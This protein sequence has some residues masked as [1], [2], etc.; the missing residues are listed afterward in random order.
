MT[1]VPTRQA[2]IL[3]RTGSS[4]T[5]TQPAIKI[6]GLCKSYGPVDVLKNVSLDVFPG[7]VVC[8]IGPSGAGKRGSFANSSISSER[9]TRRMRKVQVISATRLLKERNF[10]CRICNA[11]FQ[12]SLGIST[13]HWDQAAPVGGPCAAR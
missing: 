13:E 11:Y 4:T 3:Q 2:S 9:R 12:A 10:P 8:V 7:E 1:P 5:K 6:R